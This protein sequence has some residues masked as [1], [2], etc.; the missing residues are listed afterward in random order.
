MFDIH[1][2]LQAAHDWPRRCVL[3][4]RQCPGQREG[5][6]VKIAWIDPLSGLMARSA[7]TS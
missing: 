1:F 5:E 3:R 4:G 7:R 6:T 2:E